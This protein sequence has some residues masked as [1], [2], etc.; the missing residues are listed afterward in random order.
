M[1]QPEASFSELLAAAELDSLIRRLPKA[2]LH[3]HL[4]GTLEPEM[5]IAKA[6]KHGIQLPYADEAAVRAA[7]R[8][9]NLQSF[10]DLYY[11]ATAVLRDQDDFYDLTW[12]YLQ[13]AKADGVVHVEAFIDPQ[14]HTTRG[15][16]LEAVMTGVLDALN[17]GHAELGIS[18]RLIPNVLRHLS[19]EA[20][21][22]ML[23]ALEPW[24]TAIHGFGLDSSELEHPPSKF[25]HLFARVRALGFPVVAHAGEE[26]PPEYIVEALD[27]LG[28]VRIDHGIRA[29]ED[30]AL[31]SRLARAQIPL[32]VC[33]LSN[34]RLC[35]VPDL[36]A[37]PLRRLFEAGCLVTINSDDP[38]YFGGY[39]AAN[40]RA[41][42]EALGFTREELK[43]LAAMSI[44]ASWLNDAV[45]ARHLAAIDAMGA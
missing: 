18:Y 44:R 7:Y 38:A 42:A 19:Q 22:A 8:F 25:K 11:A 36:A 24:Y 45:K 43:R 3:V 40:Y 41:V 13:R 35:V 4:E 29:I 30:P 10:L 21:E 37:H 14:A 15:V 5:L 39:V 9:T 1:S 20:G 17:D 33:P 23:E 28:A 12:A 16:A 34:V 6:R 31:T 27:A 32:T 26:G 2:E